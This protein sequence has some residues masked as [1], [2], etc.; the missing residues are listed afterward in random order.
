MITLRLSRPW[1][2]PRAPE[3]RSGR[4]AGGAGLD[5][6]E[7]LITL[8][9]PRRLSGTGTWVT[10]RFQDMGDSSATTRAP[11]GTFCSPS[12]REGGKVWSGGRESCRMFGARGPR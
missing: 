2:R 7:K 9:A 3:A 11:L 1:L 4:R 5:L 8:V 10:H 12:S 6:V